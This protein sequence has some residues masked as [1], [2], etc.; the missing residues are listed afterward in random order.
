MRLTQF[1]LATATV[2]SV[3]LPL[4]APARATTYG[5]ITI[6]E[7]S[8]TGGTA[9]LAINDSGQ[10]T[11]RYYDSAGY[12]GYLDTNGTFSTFDYPG[13]AAGTTS[14]VGINNA[15]QIVGTYQI[16]GVSYGFLDTSGSFTTIHEPS[17]YGVVTGINDSGQMV[18]YFG[19]F[20]GTPGVNHGFVDTAGTFTAIDVPTA[21]GSPGTVGWSMN[22]LGDV[23]GYYSNSTGTHGFS[24]TNGSITAIDVPTGT[25]GT[26]LVLGVNDAGQIAGY[27]NGGGSTHG[28]VDTNGSFASIDIPGASNTY[29]GDINNLGQIVGDYTDATGRLHGFVGT[30]TSVP[31]PASLLVLSTG[32]LGLGWIRRRYA[33][34]GGGLRFQSRS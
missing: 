6:N 31:E 26:T 32:L 15:G 23:V 12:H 28:F 13:A 29:I 10:V 2:S 24:D 7:P 9:S 11:G 5:F 3:A 1:L 30:P 33:T 18:G 25:T 8:G 27:Y 19:D 34:T 20:N 17:G 21:T 16:A 14:P 22:N 4:I